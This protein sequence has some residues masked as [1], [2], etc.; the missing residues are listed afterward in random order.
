MLS[1]A[2]APVAFWYGLAY[3]GT[4]FIGTPGYDPEYGELRVGLYLQ[5][6]MM[7]DL[8][9]DPTVHAVDYGFGDAQYKRSFGDTAWEEADVLLFA[10]TFRA[11]RINAIRTSVVLGTRLAK[12]ALG[13]ERV[14]QLKRRARRQRAAAAA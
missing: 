12:R 3:A 11:A 7:E 9:A 2:G 13:P 1:I 4:F 5:M 8:C 14:G 10:P 6:R